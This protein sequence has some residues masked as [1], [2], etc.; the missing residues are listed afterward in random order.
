MRAPRMR[1]AVFGASNAGRLLAGEMRTAGHTV[2]AL[3]DLSELSNYQALIVAVGDARLA[4]AVDLLE[5]Y[6]HKG[7][8]VFHTCLSRG[9]QVLDPLETK[10]CVVAAVAPYSAERWAVTTV[11]ELVLGEAQFTAASFSDIE[12][13]AL[14][15]RV[16]YAQ[17]LT[18]LA[19]DANADVFGDGADVTAA[20]GDALTALESSEVI[21]AF[22]SLEEP[23]MRR[24]YLEATRRMGEVYHREEL[25]MWALQEETR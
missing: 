22:R 17:M 12:R 6:V 24:A 15:A 5:G 8:I 23:G 1:V 25:E 16:Y 21:A 18:L 19:V 4:Q 9:V 11:D 10:G 20:H 3:S 2:E 7:L 13:P 14:A